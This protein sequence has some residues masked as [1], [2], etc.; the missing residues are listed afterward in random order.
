MY[1]STATIM[2]LKQLTDTEHVLSP[3]VCIFQDT[4]GN[5]RQLSY[6]LPSLSEKLW[7]YFCHYHC[8][9]LLVHNS[10]K[11][12]CKKNLMVLMAV[13]ICNYVNLFSLDPGR[14][15]KF[16]LEWSKNIVLFIIFLSK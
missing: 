7:Y 4:A 3:V 16:R 13:V 10:N 12:C 1:F 2:A 11:C 5:Q 9:V 8:F 14:I 15:S 6:L